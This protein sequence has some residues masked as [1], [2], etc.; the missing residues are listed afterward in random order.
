MGISSGASTWSGNAL[1]D[2][3]TVVTLIQSLSEG[4]QRSVFKV[5]SEVSP[6]HAHLIMLTPLAPKVNSISVVNAI[7]I[8]AMS[9]IADAKVRNYFLF[10]IFAVGN[11]MNKKC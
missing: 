6:E 1:S 9:L 10:R 11:N 7:D 2:S 8:F 3:W 4:Q 5:N